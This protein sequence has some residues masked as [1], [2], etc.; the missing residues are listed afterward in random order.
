MGDGLKTLTFILGLCVILLVLLL[1]SASIAWG[2][3]YSPRACFGLAFAFVPLIA[4]LLVLT[5][6]KA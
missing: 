1:A 2:F 3:A 6:K 5:R 4:L